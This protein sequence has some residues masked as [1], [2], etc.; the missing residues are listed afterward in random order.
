MTIFDEILQR[1][2]EKFIAR[3]GREPGPEDP[4]F[5]RPVR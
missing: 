5:R 2:R 1:Q 4:I 3:Y